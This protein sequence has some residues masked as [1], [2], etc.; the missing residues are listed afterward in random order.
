MTYDPGKPIEGRVYHGEV[1]IIDD[2]WR[3]GPP[4]PAMVK[5]LSEWWEAYQ[6]RQRPP[7]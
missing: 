7:S 2:L 5:L 3:E 1:F 6:R 4:S